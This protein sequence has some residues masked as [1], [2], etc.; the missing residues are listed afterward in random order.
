MLCESPLISTSALGLPRLTKNTSK[1]FLLLQWINV[2]VV[3]KSSTMLHTEPTFGWK[4]KTQNLAVSI[5]GAEGVYGNWGVLI[6][7]WEASSYSGNYI[8]PE[9]KKKCVSLL[10]LLEAAFIFTSQTAVWTSGVF[11]GGLL[12]CGTVAFRWWLHFSPAELS[13]GSCG[14]L[15][16]W[17][18]F[19][20]NECV[21]L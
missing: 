12:T 11:E 7:T 2:P 20:N 15:R 5:W 21:Y 19:W 17:K 9:K 18:E 13:S 6:P 10:L 16:V 14:F 3:C 1:S 8:S 4:H